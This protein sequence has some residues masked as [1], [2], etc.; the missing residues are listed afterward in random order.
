MLHG[1]VVSR[2]AIDRQISARTGVRHEFLL[3]SAHGAPNLTC[4]VE[5]DAL[6]FPDLMFDKVLLVH[7]LEAADNARRMLREVWRVLKDDG[8]LLIAIE[9]ADTPAHLMAGPGHGQQLDLDGRGNVTALAALDAEAARRICEA[10][11]AEGVEVWFDAD[12]GLEHGDEWD[13]NVGARVLYKLCGAAIAARRR[14][15]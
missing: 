13:A 7:G 2:D 4:T 6:P 15:R 3:G 12:G 14:G 1:L 9:T 8:R 11:R 10:L 5:E